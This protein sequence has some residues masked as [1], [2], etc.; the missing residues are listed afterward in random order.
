MQKSSEVIIVDDKPFR[1]LST[2]VKYLEV[3]SLFPERINEEFCRDFIDCFASEQLTQQ[4]KQFLTKEFDVDLTSSIES[5][6]HQQNA[7]SQRSIIELTANGFDAGSKAMHLY[8]TEGKY[9]CTDQGS[10]IT[11][12]CLLQKK[13]IPKATTN[14]DISQSIGRFGV[15]FFTALK[16]LEDKNDRIKVETCTRGARGLYYEFAFIDDEYWFHVSANAQHSQLGTRITILSDD[17]E[18]QTMVESVEKHFAFNPFGQVRLQTSSNKETVV[19]DLKPAL[20]FYIH[21]A[22][23]SLFEPQTNDQCIITV[24]GQTIETHSFNQQRHTMTVAIN[25]AAESQLTEQRNKVLLDNEK[26]VEQIEQIILLVE[27]LEDKFRLPFINT[28]APF[29]KS[30][31]DRKLLS[32][33]KAQLPE[34]CYLPDEPLYHEYKSSQR[35]LIHPDIIPA[36]WADK[37]GKQ[38]L[39][40]H[41]TDRLFSM[42]MNPFHPPIIEDKARQ[43]IFI[44]KHF[45]DH[46]LPD[47]EYKLKLLIEVG[48]YNGRW[49]CAISTFQITSPFQNQLY[50]QFELSTSIVVGRGKTFDDGCQMKIYKFEYNK[51]DFYLMLHDACRYVPVLCDEYFHPLPQTKFQLLTAKALQELRGNHLTSWVTLDESDRLMV[52][53]SSAQCYRLMDGTGQQLSD[54][55]FGKCRVMDD[56]SLDHYPPVIEMINRHFY[57]IEWGDNP[58]G[59]VWTRRPY[60]T[61]DNLQAV[62][63]NKQG[64]VV[65]EFTDDKSRRFHLF[66][67]KCLIIEKTHFEVLDFSQGECRCMVKYDHQFDS[68]FHH[69]AYVSDIYIRYE[70]DAF[71]LYFQY[72]K[73]T[74]GD[75]TVS[76]ENSD[77]HQHGRTTLN[78]NAELPEPGN[79]LEIKYDY[80]QFPKLLYRP[81][82]YRRLTSDNGK[83]N[84]EFIMQKHHP[85]IVSSI[86]H[87]Y[88]F[89]DLPTTLFRAFEPYMQY[90][91]YVPSALMVEH[92]LASINRLKMTHERV[93]W[94]YLNVLNLCY[95]L[96]P[97]DSTR[98]LALPLETAFLFFGTGAFN[99]FEMTFKDVK[100]YFF[101]ALLFG[102]IDK[103]VLLSKLDKQTALITQWVFYNEN[104]YLA[105]DSKSNPIE[106]DLVANASITLSQL[107]LVNCLSSTAYA[108]IQSMQS[109][110]QLINV[111][112]QGLN[113]SILQRQFQHYCYFQNPPQA[114]AYINQLIRYHI[115]GKQTDGQSKIDCTLYK[116][117]QHCVLKIEDKT[118]LTVKTV[119]AT[120]FFSQCLLKALPDSQ[121]VTLV[122]GCGD[123]KKHRLHCVPI[124]E[125]NNLGQSVVVDASMTWQTRDEDFC[126]YQFERVAK[127][128]D[129]DLQAAIYH[130]LI[131]RLGRYLSSLLVDLTLNKT[132]VNTNL[133]L[134]L[135]LN[136]PSMGRISIYHAAEC[137]F[138][139]A[140][141][142]LKPIPTHFLQ[143]LPQTFQQYLKTHGI[144]INFPDTIPLSRDGC[145]FLNAD[146]FEKR[147]KTVIKQMIIYSCAKI[148]E[149]FPELQCYV[150]FDLIDNIDKYRVF[151]HQQF[152]N[153][154][155]DLKIFMQGSL[156]DNFAQYC[157]DQSFFYFL[158]NLPI[159]PVN[160]QSHSLFDVVQLYKDN[161]LADNQ[162]PGLLSGLINHHQRHSTTEKAENFS[163]TKNIRRALPQK[164]A[165]QCMMDFNQQAVSECPSWC[166][167]TDTMKRLCQLINCQPEIRL[168]TKELAAKAFVIVG[169]QCIYFNPQHWSFSLKTFIRSLKNNDHE[170]YLKVL[171][172]MLVTVSHELTHI[173]DGT[174]CLTHNAWFTG[175]QQ[176]LLMQMLLNLDHQQL[177]EQLKPLADNIDKA[178]GI[179]HLLKNHLPSHSN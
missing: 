14:T 55:R 164:T 23:V 126:G 96:L 82:S 108:D 76:V 56:L 61:G 111:Q 26:T 90:F 145:D 20:T 7:N 83:A 143:H 110:Q 17:I 127:G 41:G 135:S 141:L 147:M 154:D 84:L 31:H 95:Q 92:M 40:W 156:P 79:D 11:E 4:I 75:G 18:E 93:L 114:H 22:I 134:C 144:V 36:N 74:I 1:R 85:E 49:H 151:I 159:Y 63:V 47:H 65:R 101:N 163:F 80:S 121:S 87:T 117:D 10:G 12:Q 118:A 155:R 39:Q 124:Y 148:I 43:L 68:S 19:N 170:T 146:Q 88:R 86:A 128:L 25:L 42:E 62:I 119:L 104:P 27:Q 54:Y 129:A 28:L 173:K 51:Q 98:N 15:G 105:F 35:S 73:F 78:S 132:V 59:V 67:E 103:A 2:I 122:F 71:A 158:Y 139:V 167:F 109:L 137:M 97:R 160:G 94:R 32:A 34:G 153:I 175:R 99:Q 140:G 150:P 5:D 107:A 157:Q 53:D 46:C 21:D 29:I 131:Y 57:F 116:S 9:L 77:P 8:V 81:I 149:R 6:I 16:H 152:P 3:S 89:I 102:R 70:K 177:F 176:K 123:G 58:R 72:W 106:S 37:A 69:V 33:L 60:F 112:P 165:E 133:E 136:I 120:R 66:D 179:K 45:V 130:E 174:G 178:K 24:S 38:L 91:S 30:L 64:D 172:Q 113:L 44:Q 166:L 100:Q 162:M 50:Q 171:G 125:K 142:P 13:L 169:K 115:K 168:S 48:N 138:T 52:L 161:I